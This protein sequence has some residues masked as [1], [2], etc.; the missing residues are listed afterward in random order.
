[1]H[2]A[3]AMHRLVACAAHYKELQLLL[4]QLVGDHCLNEYLISV[5]RLSALRAAPKNQP[6]PAALY[7]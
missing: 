2:A 7:N 1:M 3:F 6:Q 4:I 5:P